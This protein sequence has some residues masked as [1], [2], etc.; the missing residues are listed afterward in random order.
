MKTAYHCGVGA[1][2]PV[3]G[4]HKRRCRVLLADLLFFGLCV[5]HGC[6]QRPE[7][8]LLHLRLT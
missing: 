1:H 4:R 7:A 3:D 5:V 2:V 8:Y 6:K